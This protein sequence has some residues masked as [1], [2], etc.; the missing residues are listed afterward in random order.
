M[1]LSFPSS[2]TTGQQSTQNG[3]TY[4]WTG[5]AWELV[6]ASGGGSGEDTLLRSLFV[7]GAPTSVSAVA[8]N[9]QAVVS[10]TAP[11]GVIAQAPI[12]DYVVQ[13]KPAGGLWQ[14]FSD[15]TSTATSATVT[16]L[17][18]GTAYT[19]KVAATNAVG[20]GSYSTASSA[21]TPTAGDALW[22][23]VQLLLPGDTSV[24]DV[25]SYSRSVSAS[26]GAAVSTAQKRWGAGSI[27]FDGTAS[28]LSI[29]A[30]AFTLAGDFVIEGWVYPTATNS[31]SPLIEGRALASYQNFVA[32]LYSIGGAYRVDFVTDGGA[33]VRLTSSASVSLNAWTHIAI[34]RSGSTIACYIDGTRDTNTITYSS[35]ITPAASNVWVGRNVDGNYFPGFIDDLRITVGSDRGYTGATIQVPTAAFPDA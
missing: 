10:W 5:Y 27:A 35:T 32:G 22:S 12:T 3:R 9:A 26:G 17:T 13:F 20:T 11:T 21:V 25:S 24:N 15:G 29:P 31:Y 8:G 4:S 14:T 1:P 19:F 2:P 18:N 33:G 7:P 34:V 30:S 6:A 16:G 23:S 28:H